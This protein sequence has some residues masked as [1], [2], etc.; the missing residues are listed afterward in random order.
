MDG[1]MYSGI[2]LKLKYGSSFIVA[3]VVLIYVL[4]AV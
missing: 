3:E 1:T 2:L 4:V